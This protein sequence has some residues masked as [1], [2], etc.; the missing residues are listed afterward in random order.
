MRRCSARRGDPSPMPPPPPKP[1]R[2][3]MPRSHWPGG[4]L[5]RAL[6]ADHLRRRA[7]RCRFLLLHHVADRN[8]LAERVDRRPAY[9]PSSADRTRRY[10]PCRTQYRADPA[11]TRTVPPMTCNLKVQLLR[12]SSSRSR[13]TEGFTRL[14]AG[15]TM[16]CASSGSTSTSKSIS[17]SVAKCGCLVQSGFA[18]VM[19]AAEK[20]GQGT[21]RAPAG[22]AHRMAPAQLSDRR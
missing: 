15:I 10:C 2:L 3:P 17:S 11:S 6:L 13:S 14:M 16:S 20:R 12:P 22:L 8:R 18:I 19:L 7:A 4:E 1:P 5:V 21:Q 9:R